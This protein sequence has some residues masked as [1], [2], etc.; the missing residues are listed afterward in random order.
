MKMLAGLRVAGMAG[1]L[2]AAPGRAQVESAAA[3]AEEERTF[4]QIDAISFASLDSALSRLDVF[5]QVP[6]ENL[7]FT[8]G[9]EGYSASYEIQISIYDSLGRLA[10][11]KLWTEQVKTA[12]FDESVSSQAYSLTQR[13]FNIAPG[14]YSIGVI[15]RDNETKLSRKQI[16]QMTVQDYARAPFALS[17]I[18]LVRKITFSG[19]HKSIVPNVSTNVG[20]LPEGFFLFFEAYN[21]SRRD[22]V[23]FVATVFND[24][25]ERKLSVDTMEFLHAGRSQIFMKV[26]NSKLVLGNYKV[27]VRAVP[28]SQAADS[29]GAPLATTS[30][31]FM[32]RWRGLPM[33]LADLDLAI[34]Q[35]QYIAKESE[36]ENIK[37]ATTLEEK[38]KRFL[39]FW[40]TKDPNPNTPRNEKMEDYYAKVEYANKHFGHY[41]EGWKTD[42]GMVYIRFGAPNNVDRH[43]FDIDAKPYEVWSYYDLNYQFV[44]VD[45]TGFGDYRLITPLWDVWQRA[46]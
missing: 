22:S 27:F 25:N 45:Q 12:T 35:L 34:E 19:E 13:V 17:D 15:I 20:D 40:K 31:A 8:K 37:A 16:R 33:A 4:F 14:K 41:I 2:L 7:S 43:P 29:S 42:M 6:Y 26:D 5:V 9:D 30:R 46:K 18:M 36:I 44:F 11:E 38:Q 28:L 10:T 23:K 32:V 21:H 3:P 39:E 1:L 24:K